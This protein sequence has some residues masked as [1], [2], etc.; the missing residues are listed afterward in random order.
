LIA[1]L[2]VTGGI[3]CKKFLDVKPLDNLA[4][5]SFFQNKQDVESNLWDIYGLLRDKLGA[6]PLLPW[7]GDLR[8]GMMGPSPEATGRE[9]RTMVPQNQLEV[10]V[11]ASSAQYWWIGTFN[12]GSLQQWKIF[13]KIVQ[14]ANDLYYE[15][16]RRP[17]SGLSGSDVKRYQAEAVFLRCIAYFLM[18]RQ[19]GDVCYYT[20]AYHQAALPR[21]NMDT[22]VNNCLAD[23]N[24][25]K[26]DLPWQYNEP[27]Y[28]GVR[29][30][31]GSVLALMMNLDMWGAG[32][33][34]ANAKKYEQQAAELGGEV[35]QSGAYELLPLK[36]FNKVFKGRTKESLF[37]I[38]Q[39]SNYGELLQYETFPDMVLHYPYKRPISSHQY[40]FC[41]FRSSFL[42]MLYPTGQPDL[43]V[44]YWFDENMFSD[45]GNFQFLKFTNVYAIQDNED[46]NPDNDIIIFRYA[47]IILLRAEALADLGQTAE[48]IK[49]L[50][51][52]RAR[53]QSNLY[54]G[55]G[56][57]QLSDAIFAERAKELM[58]EGH[59]YYDLVRTGRV[60]DPRW[61][62]YPMT[63]SQF[64]NGGWT[65]PLDPAVQS[66][67]PNI[68]L[69]NYWLK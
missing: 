20:D 27:A 1:L 54:S 65:W 68:Q 2:F 15:L 43:R 37:E 57:V 7:A 36:D 29:A 47:G 59:Y 32:F 9:Y 10:M 4:G 51:I 13:Y 39:N 24:K 11:S 22:V 21:T 69:N 64:N 34:K 44:Q 17:I 26:D 52:V 53:A 30:S 35:V 45:N 41:Y 48:A 61:D 16:G 38:V 66:H 33:D 28:V 25:V 63:Q 49:M 3:G 58:G 18:V 14:S 12:V 67:N 19:W 40:S 62:Y 6:A 8:S 42:K 56:G 60:M 5:N 46:V 50:N 23:L 31:K 55:P